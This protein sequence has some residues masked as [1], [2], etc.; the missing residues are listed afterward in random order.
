MDWILKRKIIYPVLINNHDFSKEYL[1]SNEQSFYISKQQKAGEFQPV[2]LWNYGV[3]NYCLLL[4]VVDSTLTP[5][6]HTILNGNYGTGI[7]K[8]DKNISYW[9]QFKHSKVN[10][11]IITSCKITTFYNDLNSKEI[12]IDSIILKSEILKNGL[13][14]T[15]RT[16]SVRIKL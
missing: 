16:D 1:D 4:V 6:S 11:T 15:Q 8:S 7:E 9:T 12:Y 3:D 13:I 5:I 2:I 14:K 10:G